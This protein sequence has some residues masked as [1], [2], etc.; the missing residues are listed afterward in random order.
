MKE[1]IVCGDIHGEIEVVEELMKWNVPVCF[2][3][4]F[5]DSYTRS[6]ADQ[7]ACLNMVLNAVEAEPE[8]YF[9]IKGNHELSYI[10]SHQRCS[11]WNAATQI[12]MNHLK[13]RCLRLMR[14]YMWWE[15]T[16]GNPFLITHAGLTNQSV[17]HF[18]LER[19]VDGVKEYLHSDEFERVKFNVGSARGGFG[20]KPGIFWCDWWQEFQPIKGINQ[21]VGHSA[22][23]PQ[24]FEGVTGVVT[25]HTDGSK[26][27]NVDCL[28]TK[29]EV[30]LLR[31]DGSVKILTLDVF[32]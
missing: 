2:V 8:K 21:V 14:D 12:H 13:D 23:R 28:Q 22:H 15:P 1:L 16:E 7:I 31:E 5:L 4:D 29:K 26:N 24:R 25:K 27:Y 19:G 11:G 9:T 6:V 20:N 32:D 3:G 17:T 30:L 10:I 18:Y